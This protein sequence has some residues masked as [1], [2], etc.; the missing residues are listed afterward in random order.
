MS[1]FSLQVTYRKGRPFAAYI[2][3]QAGPTRKSA[4]TERVSPEVTIDYSADGAPLGIEIISPG[5]V[6]LEEIHEAFDRMGLTRPEPSELAPL[7]VA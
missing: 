2:Y 6:S 1:T 7:R 5:H 4:R 3:L